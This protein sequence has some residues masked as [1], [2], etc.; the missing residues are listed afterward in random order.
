MKIT[1]L[2]TK[3]NILTQ[4]HVHNKDMLLDE[5]INLMD[6]NNITSKEI[7][8]KAVLDRE[9]ESTTNMGVGVC[10]PHGRSSSV[11]KASLSL[12]ISNN[13]IDYDGNEPV[14]IAFM[15]AS[16]N[17]DD[18]SHIEVLGTLS[19]LLISDDFRN[20]LLNAKDTSE[21]LEIIDNAENMRNDVEVNDVETY[22]VLAVT[23]CPTG[24]AHTFMA[25]ESLEKAAG[26]LNITIK[27]ETNG[28]DGVKNRLSKS[29]IEK[30][31]AIIIAADTKV[32]MGRFEGK[33]LVK[34]TVSEGISKPKDLINK[35]LSDKTSIYHTNK[36]KYDDENVDDEKAGRKIYKHLMNGV[37]YMLPFVVGGGILIALSFMLDGAN[38]GNSS[39]GSGNDLASFFNRAGGLSFGM[40]FPILAGFIAMSI[41]DRPGFAVG[42]VG[43]LIAREGVML[44]SSDN[45]VSSGFFGALIAGFAAGYIILLLKKLLKNLPSSLDG[46]KPVLLYPLIGILMI[47]FLMIVIVN[48]PIS[49][50]N[51]G[52]NSFLQGMSSGSKVLLGAVL[53]GMMAIDFG[54]PIN[55][56]AYV[57][58]TA[59]IATGQFEIMAAVMA[60]GMVPPLG[61]ALATTF[62]K[63]SFT[64]KERQTTV[65]NYIM[66]LSFITEGAIPFAAA[67]PLAVIPSCAIGSAVAGGLSML[68]GSLLPAPHGGIFVVPIMTNGLMF[69]VAVLIGSLVTMILLKLLK[70]MTRKQ[71]VEAL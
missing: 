12:I 27:V 17:N 25:A 10:I 39:F 50:L 52:V 41:A 34:T 28:S 30:A 61:I 4:V 9:K 53:G 18:N 69:I 1:D 32:E 24:I 67:D 58:G 64:K 71:P 49:T 7:F 15:I 42:V 16:S 36:D 5:L 37:S 13:D 29:E 48:P 47:S 54:G 33:K 46:T 70:S 38:A 35:A 31:D 68:F 59:S 6:D 43:G 22:K 8:K 65:T 57:F 51:S 44:G 3:E 21:V 55:K 40:M 60:G 23:A 14:R 63:N 62:F 56:T 19:R 2:L 26:E 20:A 11:Q 66:G 45:Y